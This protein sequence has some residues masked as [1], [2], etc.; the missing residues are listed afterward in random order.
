MSLMPVDSKP[1]HKLNKSS[2][3]LET[4]KGAFTLKNIEIIY[5]PVVDCLHL[6]QEL[7]S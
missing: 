2:D 1:K 4:E 3:F 6:D 5:V 7:E